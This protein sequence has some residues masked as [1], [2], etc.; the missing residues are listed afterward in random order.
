MRNKSTS[1]KEKLAKRRAERQN[2]LNAASVDTLK[3]VTPQTQ[4]KNVGSTK[5][6]A[7]ALKTDETAPTAAVLKSKLNSEDVVSIKYNFSS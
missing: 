7:D 5:D 3:P 6:Q 1:L 2:I 4:T